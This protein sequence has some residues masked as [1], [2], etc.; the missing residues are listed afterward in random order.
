MI[1]IKK[2]FILLVL[3]ISGF[4]A[5]AQQLYK[6]TGTI[7]SATSAAGL[8][9]ATIRILENKEGVSADTT[10]NY[11]ISL[12]PGKYTFVVSALS[13]FAVRKQIVVKGDQVIDFELKEN[14]NDLNEVVISSGR[15]VRSLSSPQMGA[16]RLSMS[17]IKNIPVILGERDVLKS[18]QLLPGIKSAGEGGSGFYV[19]GGSADQNLILLDDIPVY[20][21]SHFLGFF[22]TFNPD[23]VEDI[24]VYKTGMP[25][26]YGGRLSS[27]LDIRM[28]EGSREGFSA[29]GGIGLI[30]SKITLE[31][32]VQKNKS[33]FL[34]SARRTYIDALLSL[35]SDSTIN[36]NTMYF[37]DVNAKADL[38]LNENNRLMFTGY[39]GSDKLGLSDIFGLSWGNT[40]ASLQLKHIYSPVLSSTTTGSFTSY[41][42][43]V[44]IQSGTM[45]IDIFSR[46]N[47]LTFKHDFLWLK[48]QKTKIRF[49][50][51]SIYH[52][53]TPGEIT[54]ADSSN[55]NPVNYQKRYALEN[56]VFV[57]SEWQ[58]SKRLSV[59]MG[60]R[61]NAF[62]VLG[63]GDFYN[64]DN[65]GNTIDTLH[66]QSGDMVKTYVNLEPRL[67]LSYLLNTSSSLKASYV[68]N[69]QNMHMVSNSTS[70]RPTDK[71]LSSTNNIKPELSDQ[72]SLGYYRNLFGNK[73]ELNVETYYKTMQNQIDYRDGADVSNADL[74]E[75]QLLYGKGRAY[76][77]E[78]LLKKKQ[79]PFT[80]WISYTLSKTERQIN[81]IND[82]RWYNARQDR[83]HDIAL[84]G[85]YELN[86]KWSLSATWIYYTGDAITFP[87]G[88]YNID[89]QVFFYYTDRN[90]YRMPAYHRLDL[91]ATMQLRKRKTYSSELSF[92]LYNAYGRKNAYSIT[93]RES[94]TDPAKTEAVRTTLFQYV[95]S[96]SY[97]FRFL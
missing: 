88:K 17:T 74:I 58:A 89:G 18:I 44:E 49:G 42:N 33:S 35:S 4:Q 30:S 67:A 20:N 91:G 79:G 85:M 38:Q 63:K 50:L 10:G 37:Y 13:M 57:S 54:A 47:D 59:S 70:S 12:Q 3:A 39:L 6:I 9:N 76:G 1:D 60:L 7:K 93:F 94:E 52:T 8:D 65:N 28:K 84:V 83:T 97:N 86:K 34:I 5:N 68:R 19:R 16:E 71:W 72:V 21:A 36:S 55:Y 11:T 73:Y 87:S 64:L 66:Y 27:V 90:A 61:L 41:R 15:A 32:P 81:G 77:L 45:D 69:T 22:S 24:T 25:A 48:S 80:G 26:Q 78:F 29:S 92:S 95:P 14:Q 43:R 75:S 46:I 53:V 40:L 51:S 23:A 56:A 31:G 2:A 82:G 62:S 96:I